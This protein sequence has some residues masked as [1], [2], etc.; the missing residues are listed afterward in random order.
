MAFWWGLAGHSDLLHRAAFMHVTSRPF[1][2]S[3]KVKGHEQGQMQFSRDIEIQQPRGAMAV[4]PLESAFIKTVLPLLSGPY[5][6]RTLLWP[7]LFLTHCTK[8]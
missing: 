8:E 4:L 3:I 5:A 7:G 6:P 2:P 1:H